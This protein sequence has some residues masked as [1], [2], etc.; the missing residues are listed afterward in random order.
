MTLRKS[1]LK[2]VLTELVDYVMVKRRWTLPDIDQL[3]DPSP[4]DAAREANFVPP[5]DPANLI[6]VLSQYGIKGTFKDFHIGAVVTTY[7]VAVPVGTHLKAITRYQDDLARDLRTPSLRV[8]KGVKDASTIGFEIE[9]TDRYTVNFKEMFKGI[10]DGLKLPVILGEDTYG[11]AV[12]ADLTTMPHLLVAGQTGSGKSA[13][14]NG[15]IATLISKMTPAELQLLIVDPKGYEFSAYQDLPHLY[16]ESGEH[17]EIASEVDDARHLLNLAV[18]E[19]ERRGQ[20][21][22][23]HRVK[24]LDDYNSTAK[25]KLPYIVFI[26]DEFADL[27]MMGT[28]DQKKDVE[29]KIVRIAQKARAVGIHMVLATQKPLASIMTSLIKANMPA[30]I[31]FSVTSGTDSRVILDEMGA[32]TL[33][34]SGDMLF[35]DPSARSEY[36]R[37]RRVQAPWISD[38]D[39]ETL[40]N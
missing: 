29:T 32:E 36:A 15:L 21:F 18:E 20:L 19:M 1:F 22:D 13:F 28:R 35:R 6:S 17:V 2:N 7:E 40:L 14:M 38:K 39:V 12:Y 10:P 33:A 37:L 5:V 4:A 9:N 30:R 26:V 23:E 24:K 3:S 31:A 27:M 34:G 25:V 11:E 8:I 16:Q